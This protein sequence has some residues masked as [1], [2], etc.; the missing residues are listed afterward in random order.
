MK[1]RSIYCKITTEKEIFRNIKRSLL[2][3]GELRMVN[4]N[5]KTGQGKIT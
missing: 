4:G 2:N 5:Y 3:I 1:I